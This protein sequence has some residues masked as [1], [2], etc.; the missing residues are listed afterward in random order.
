MQDARR[1]IL[2]FPGIFL[3]KPIHFWI[4]LLYYMVLEC[5]DKRV[6]GWKHIRILPKCMIPFMDNVPYD[7]WADYIEN[8]EGVPDK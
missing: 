6:K 1:I 4:I 2:D 8:V 5:Q 3:H 7:E